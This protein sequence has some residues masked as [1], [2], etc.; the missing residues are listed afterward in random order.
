VVH[1]LLSGPSALTGQRSMFLTTLAVSHVLNHISGEI[2]IIEGVNSQDVNQMTLHTDPGCS[3]S[4]GASAFSGQ[5]KTSNCDINAPGQGTNVGCGISTTDT[6]T[7]GSGFNNEGGGVYATEWT[8]EAITIH[9][10]PRSSIPSDIASGNPD[11]STWGTPLAVFSGCNFPQAIR[12]QSIIFDTTFCGQWAGQQSVWAADPVC[13]QKAATCQDY[14]QNN[15]ADFANAYWQVNS[16][17]VFQM[18]NGFIGSAPIP[19]SS[20][21][22]AAAPPSSSVAKPTPS[23]IP[24]TLATSALSAPPAPPAVHPTI[25][26]VAYPASVQIVTVDMT[27]TMTLNSPQASVLPPN[28]CGANSRREGCI[29][30]GKLA[31]P[32]RVHKSQNRPHSSAVA[33]RRNIRVNR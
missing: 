18:G 11:P 22:P 4:S 31:N 30:K 23:A 12:N 29:S 21:T 27:T 24:T 28:A 9:H 10:F 7:Y 20:S 15:P 33:R 17:K 6:T 32:D 19:A 3:I 5:L 14:V 13:S 8:A 16:V 1:G 25:S 2:D 26:S